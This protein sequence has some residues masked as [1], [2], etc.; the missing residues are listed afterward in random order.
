MAPIYTHNGELLL[1]KSNT[2][3]PWNKLFIAQCIDKVNNYCIQSTDENPLNMI[4]I[5]IMDFSQEKNGAIAAT[6]LQEIMTRLHQAL[7]SQ[8]S[9]GR[10]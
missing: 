2:A 9:S 7:S 10:S 1:E 6:T 3:Q 5:T 8:Y 4:Q